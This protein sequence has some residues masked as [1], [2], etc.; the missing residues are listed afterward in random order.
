VSVIN[1]SKIS[2]IGK[3]LDRVDGPVKVMGKARYSAE[4]PVK[5]V[6]YAVAVGAAIANGKIRS[7]N[8]A[9]A[10][11]APG[12]I[13][14][15]THKNRPP[16]VQG[17]T[18]AGG[19]AQGELRMPLADNVITHA[20]QYVA[21]VVAES[22][23]CATQAATLIKFVYIEE[24][25]L[26]QMSD[27]RATR[28][29]A[30][31][32]MGQPVA[33]TRGLAEPALLAAAVKV[34]NKYYTPTQNH[35]PMETHATLSIWE[36]DKLTVYD[37][38][39]GLDNTRKALAQAFAIPETNV[40]VVCKYI[41][42]AFGCKGAMWPHVLLSTM[43][44][45]VVNRPVKLVL[46]RPQMF[47][48]VGH[49]AE[50]EQRVA[51]GASGDGAIVSIIHQGSSHTSVNGE[52][53]ETFTKST[54]MMYAA[55]NLSVS[56]ELVRL[57]KQMPTFMRAPGE[58]PGSFALE[59]A[60]DELAHALNMDPIELRLKNYAKSDPDSGHP[61]S[62]KGLDQCYKVGAEKIGW[63]KRSRPGSRKEGDWLVGLGM[64]SATY[65]TMHFN[66][67]C[68]ALLKADGSFLFKSSTHEMGTGTRTVMAQIGAA[69]L[70]VP[71]E[72][73]DFELGDTD[74]PVAPISGGSATVSTVGSAV[75]GAAL[76]IQNQLAQK[77]SQSAQSPFSGLAVEQIALSNGKFS[78]AGRAE[79]LSY[80]DALKLLQLASLEVKFQTHFN[81]RAKKF[82]MH[83]F[84]AHFIE[85]KVDQDLGIVRVTRSVGVFA[86][87]RIINEKTC[88]SQVQGGITMGIG[89]ALEEA[90]IC[91]HRSGRIVNASLGE[92]YVPVNADIPAIE[93]H[94]ISEEDNEINSI[95]AKGIGEIGITGAAAAVANAVFNA[96]GKR[97]R[98]LPITV[99]KL[100]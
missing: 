38:T 36:G 83:S 94:F 12:V 53:I 93:V 5:K 21:L 49:R 65:P 41:G 52:F 64:A 7:I 30:D 74:F 92:Y 54:P 15:I 68:S 32:W 45:R 61:F 69:R 48:N 39:Q 63:D 1:Q 56:Q 82:S 27:K 35:N 50:T 10:E 89:M 4:F 91:D 37:A 29:P 25:P 71:V 58:T 16:L 90:T 77:L 13:A 31:K 67:T 9:E 23:E 11:K 81:D 78:T 26:V 19:G 76:E 60:M 55:T 43:A 3:G 85:V 46:T 97:I 72:N 33:K 18:F 24:D 79:S 44:A 73:V 98:N 34:D 51:I 59:S 70:G 62:S 99:D 42:G 8:T 87:G 95:G 6:S 84:G 47:T 28:F 100:I 88:R 22:I 80:V 66:A 14:V 40:R 20:G 75:D 2:L 57:N 17:K 96:T 86:N